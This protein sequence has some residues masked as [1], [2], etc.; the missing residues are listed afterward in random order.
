MN[1]AFDPVI[2]VGDLCEV[3]RIYAEFFAGLDEAG[4]DK[5]V[6]GSP[7]EWTLHETVAHLV[8]LNGAGLESIKNTLRGES[9]I[10]VGLDNRYK[11]NAYNRRGIYEHLNIPMKELCANLLDILDEAARLARDLQPDQAQLTAFLLLVSGGI[12]AFTNFSD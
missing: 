4:W 1:N 12:V 8:A 10:F 2:L 9:Y 6:K 11:F 5:P 7:K 3:R